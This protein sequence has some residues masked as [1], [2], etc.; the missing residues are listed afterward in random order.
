MIIG[1]SQRIQTVSE[2]MVH[3]DFFFLP[4]D[5]VTQRTSEREQRIMVRHQETSSTATVES[6][7]SLSDL[8]F[9][10]LFGT[11]RHPGDF[12]ETRINLLPLRNAIRPILTRI[13]NDFV[14]EDEEC[15][16]IRI[17]PFDFSEQHEFF[18]CNEDI[19]G[20][21]SYFC[22]HTVCI[23]NDDSECLTL[24]VFKRHIPVS[25]ARTSVKFNWDLEVGII[26]PALST[27]TDLQLAK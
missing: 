21:N 1:F 20:A 8:N 23:A 11:T 17:S 6:L 3:D 18:S 9:D 4:I 22:E 12:L 16:T 13:R 2:G 10:V 26:F 24:C 5:V 19:D 27:H 7:E 15:F 25:T 14:I